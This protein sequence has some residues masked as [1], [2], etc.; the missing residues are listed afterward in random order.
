MGAD[1]RE[2]VRLRDLDRPWRNPEL[3]LL[4]G[5]GS[6]LAPWAPGTFG[7]LAALVLWWWLIAPLGWPAQVAIVAITFCTGIWLSHRAARRFGL[8]DDPAIVIDEFAGLWLAL[9]GAPAE[10]LVALIGF[11]LFRL[12]DIVKPWPV[13]VADQRVPG[14]LGVMLDDLLAGALAFA[15]LQVALPVIR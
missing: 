9:A 3:L 13:S 2:Q 5:F 6:G 1:G 8:G 7:S 4:T 15:V 11:A 12:F 10:P 14:A